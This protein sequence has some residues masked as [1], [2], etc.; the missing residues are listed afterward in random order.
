MAKESKKSG[1]SASWNVIRGNAIHSFEQNGDMWCAGTNGPYMTSISVMSKEVGSD[2][3][4][5]DADLHTRLKASNA[6]V[7]RQF[8]ERRAPLYVCDNDL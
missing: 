8:F 3:W 7:E 2:V 4:H 1:M 6:E 5:R